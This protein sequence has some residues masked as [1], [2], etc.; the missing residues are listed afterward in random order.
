MQL[1]LMCAAKPSHET[2]LPV[3]GDIKTECTYAEHIYILY[4][5]VYL[6]R[7]TLFFYPDVNYIYIEKPTLNTGHRVTTTKG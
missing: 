4:L 6:P 7:H 3:F 1:H 5:H 2:V